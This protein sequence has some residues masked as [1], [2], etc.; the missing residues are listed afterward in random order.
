MNYIC[1]HCHF[2]LILVSLLRVCIIWSTI[3]KISTGWLRMQSAY[4]VRILSATTSWFCERN[5]LNGG[6]PSPRPALWSYGVSS[7]LR[8]H[9]VHASSIKFWLQLLLV[10]MA[11]T[12]AALSC[13]FTPTFLLI[14]L[15]T[16]LLA[17]VIHHN[18]RSSQF[19]PGPISFPIIGSL[20]S[21]AGG[22]IRLVKVD[23]N[24]LYIVTI[25]ID[26]RN[27]HYTC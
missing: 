19:P 5:P 4:A 17:V 15:T 6:F 12:V 7:D 11:L 3:L 10:V 20:L 16:F 8:R 22:D 23:L 24:C 9:D 26:T 25:L 13:V 21:L 1:S 2:A 18:W 14:F 27:I